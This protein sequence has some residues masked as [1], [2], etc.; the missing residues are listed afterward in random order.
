MDLKRLTNDALVCR[1]GEW[2]V[3]KRYSRSTRETYNRVAAKFLRFWG[4]RKFSAV[5]PLDVHG[6]MTESSCRDLS[7]EVVH[8]YLWALRSFFDFL[9]LR[10]VVDEVAPRLVRSRPAPR[11]LLRALSE[12]SNNHLNCVS[13]AIKSFRVRLP[14]TAGPSAPHRAQSGGPWHTKT[15]QLQCETSD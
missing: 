8:R 5:K 15:P 2:L 11:R 4:R 7:S 3:C 14:N 9:C 1:Y 10:G 6:F 12:G 13:F